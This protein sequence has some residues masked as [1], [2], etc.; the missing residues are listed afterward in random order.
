MTEYCLFPIQ[1]QFFLERFPSIKYVYFSPLLLEH[2]F[3]ALCYITNFME[4]I[5]SWESNSGSVSQ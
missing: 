4:Q 3:Q 5:S 2:I 1:L